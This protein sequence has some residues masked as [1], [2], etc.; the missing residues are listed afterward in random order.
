MAY[1]DLICPKIQQNLTDIALHAPEHFRRNSGYLD[2]I[3]AQQQLYGAELIRVE[4]PS[5]RNTTVHVYYNPALTFSDPLPAGAPSDSDGIF[6][7]KFN[8]T[9]SDPRSICDVATTNPPEIVE[10][11]DLANYRAVRFSIEETDLRNLC[12]R[13]KGEEVTKQ[14]M[15][16]FP[17]LT[18]SINRAVLGQLLTNFGAF[19]D[20]ADATARSVALTNAQ[21]E[22]LWGNFM[23]E[24]IEE[25][26]D[27]NHPLKPIIVGGK[28]FSSFNKTLNY[29]CCNDGGIDLNMAGDS[30]YYFFKDQSF[31]S[32][33]GADQFA[34]FAPGSSQFLSRNFN[35][36]QYAY[37]GDE[38]EYGTIVD[39]ISGIA[40]D[41]DITF[42]KCGK[43]WNF[44]IG[45]HFDMFYI[46]T[47]TLFPAA[48]TD[49]PMA[50]VNYHLRY[51][52]A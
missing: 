33:I 22:A 37:A 13:D 36:G 25:Y 21:N 41:L 40:Y 2:A 49:H 9:I 18:D 19:Y 15:L 6:Q 50:G 39:P 45:L 12:V 29:G 27:F 47:A 42:D 7:D 46:P 24:V 3:V 31:D 43:R 14:F 4:E 48:T 20:T 51:Q 26:D 35:I 5:G 32:V 11:T 17:R 52:M 44:T 1:S 23:R 28:R 10:I 8:P 16:N 38:F 34:V 30:E